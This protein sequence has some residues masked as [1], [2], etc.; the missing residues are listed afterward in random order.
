MARIKYII[1]QL[2]NILLFA[3]AR[4]RHVFNIDMVTHTYTQAHILNY[5]INR[6]YKLININAFIVL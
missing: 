6:R 2:N 1:R 3:C 5:V 4:K